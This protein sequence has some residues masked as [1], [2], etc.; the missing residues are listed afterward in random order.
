MPLVGGQRYFTST[1]VFLNEVIKLAISL[2]MALYDISANLPS[3]STATALFSSL[4]SAVFT[5]DSWKLAIPAMLY[6]LQNSLQYVAIS[7]LDAATFQV[8]YQLKILTTALFSVTMLGRTLSTRKWLSLVLLMIGV[9]IVQIPSGPDATSIPTLKELKDGQADLHLPR[10]LEELRDLGS[11]A[12]A[13]LTKRSATYEGIDEDFAA[14]NPQLNASIGLAAVIVACIL[15]GL[16]GVYF[17]KVVKDKTTASTPNVSVWVRNVQLSFYSLFPAL[18]IGVIFKDGENIAKSGFFVGYN[19]VVWAAIAMQATGGVVVALVVNYA[20]NIAKNFATSIS[21]VVSFLASVWFFGATIQTNVSSTLSP[22]FSL[23]IWG[24]LLL[25]Q[26]RSAVEGTTDTYR[27]LRKD[28]NWREVDFKTRDTDWRVKAL[29]GVWEEIRM[30]TSPSEMLDKLDSRVH[31]GMADRRNLIAAYQSRDNTESAP[32]ERAERRYHEAPED[33]DRYEYEIPREDV[34]HYREPLLDNF[35]QEL[36]RH[37]YNDSRQGQAAEGKARL[38]LAPISLKHVNHGARQACDLHDE[39]ILHDRQP[40]DQPAA[41]RINLESRTTQHAAEED[42]YAPTMRPAPASDFQPDYMKATAAPQN[43]TIALKHAPPIVQGIQLV[44]CH[45]LPDRFRSIFPFPLFN[46]VQSKCFQVI[47]HGNDNFVLSSPTGSGK[48]VIFELAICRL[49]TRFRSGSYK[50]VYQAPTKSLCSERQRDWQAKFG[51]LDLQCAELTGDTDPAQMRNVQNASIII[52]TPE[53]WDSMT[54]RWKDHE[55]LMQ[56]VKLFLI[57]EIHFLKEDRGATLEAVVSRMKSVGSDVRFIALSATV[58]NSDDIATWLG[59]DSMDQKLSAQRERFGEEFRPVKLQKHVCGY[60]STSNDFVFDKT[61]D[62]KLPELIAK[63]SQRKP[64]MIFCSTR[65]SCVSTA[66]LLANWWATKGPS[67]R[68]WEAPRMHIQV[69]DVELRNT[70]PSGVAFHHAGIDGSDRAIIE[71]AYLQGGVNVICCTSTLAVGV[72]LPCHFVIIKNTACYMNALV[73]CKEYSDL[74]VMQMLGRAGRPQFDD[75]AVAVI[76]TRLEK[77]KHYE[78]MVSGQEILESRLHLN[79]IDHLNAEIGL[80]T[81][82]DLYSAK[83][84]LSGTFLYVRLKENP[85]H[86]RL[87]GGTGGR[88]IDERLEHICSKDLSS[89]EQH[90]LVTS[91]NEQLRCTEFGDAMAR[92]YLQ[93]ETMKIFLGLP[94]KAK[95]SEILSALA[96]AA[97]FKEVRFR[98]G[99][100]PLYKTL[101]SSLS[102]KFPIPVDLALPA[103]KVSLIIQ[104]VLGAVDLP[105]DEKTGKHQLHLGARCWDDSPLQL[106]QVEGIGIQ[107]VR[108]LVNANVKTIED[109]ECMEPHRIEMVLS[110]NPPFGAKLL[111]MLKDFPKLRVAVKVMGQ[112]TVKPNDHVTEGRAKKLNNGQDVLFSA[113]LTS[114]SQTITCYVMC[115]EIAGTM[116]QATLNPGIP[117]SAFPPRQV[118][119]FIDNSPERQSSMGVPNTSRRRVDA[120]AA[121]PNNKM[122]GD[123]FGDDDIGDFDLMQAGVGDLD[124]RHIDTFDDKTVSTTKRNT[125]GNGKHMTS[126]ASS[127]RGQPQEKETW[128]PKKRDNGKWAC[129]HA[130]KE[131]DKCKHMCCRDGLDKAP[132]AP[133]KVAVSETAS[134]QHHISNVQASP[135]QLQTKLKMSVTKGSRGMATPASSIDHV[136]L[137]K[138]QYG[139]RHIFDTP[140]GHQQLQRLHTAV[141]TK[142]PVKSISTMKPGYSY[143]EGTTPSLTFLNT[144]ARQ[145]PQNLSSDYSN[146]RVDPDTLRGDETG[147]TDQMS[148]PRY[149]ESE[150]PEDPFQ[151][152]DEEMLDA[153]FIGY[154]DSQKLKAVS[155]IDDDTAPVDGERKYAIHQQQVATERTVVDEPLEEPHESASCP[156]ATPLSSE[157]VG[158]VHS[159]LKPRSHFLASTSSPSVQDEMAKRHAQKVAKADLKSNGSRSRKAWDTQ[160]PL[161][162][163]S[164]RLLS[165]GDAEQSSP[166]TKKRAD[167]AFGARKVERVLSTRPDNSDAIGG[168]CTAND[169]HSLMEETVD[170]ENELPTKQS[171]TEGTNVPPGY[172]GVDDWILKEFGD[173]VDFV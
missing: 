124:F 62:K 43:Q 113:Q 159:P 42:A 10:S 35:D 109:L 98:S 2:T 41:R 28:D 88:D 171:I 97:E 87:D 139:N 138:S 104:S 5:G 141:Q 127:G 8:T 123:D 172:E 110:R 112:P 94:P 67:D 68:Y 144:P 101:N 79:L 37:S 56:M 49:I 85:N 86:Y 57:D 121:A 29:E 17:E 81:I 61:L 157:T 150:Q 145:K 137:S 117:A 47:Y 161:K 69:N 66:K 54:R 119:T 27:R 75:S 12:A 38:T 11:L 55:R 128:E 95:L 140:Y 136:D 74:E 31:A 63:Y 146:N 103:H 48:T 78:K 165:P 132:K 108:K 91:D 16:A 34:T 76:M 72:N 15:S 111:E 153:S 96:Q 73:G 40:G 3:S 166:A 133:K 6:T 25:T 89:L 152:E 22:Y 162:P 120:A 93:F 114:E 9:A 115:D 23:S 163:L 148:S 131:K 126:K 53:K 21:I 151:D 158:N 92:Y 36:L 60:Q 14:A 168:L 7:N 46:A 24:I 20:D 129:N 147:V 116:R 51:V 99:E 1:A 155:E 71:K 106:K 169:T 143:K 100:K 82:T 125:S 154:E 45:K 149:V 64:I 107:A 83:K 50:V 84:W 160:L 33:Y 30:A 59:K 44:S 156:T 19:W 164:K 102:M 80:G 130:C 32:Y 58:P 52:T 105:T 142:P 90:H 13:Q 170:D 134:T 4:S 18:F 118:Q 26:P 167:E 77:V 39:S 173:V 135:N 122:T 65:T 70:I